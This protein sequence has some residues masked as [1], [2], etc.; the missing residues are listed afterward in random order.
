MF[1]LTN[2]GLIIVTSFS[3]VYGNPSLLATAFDPD[4]RGCGDGI[5]SG[6]L[7]KYM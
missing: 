4:H 2:I 5:L 7:K 1:I 6:K 3:L